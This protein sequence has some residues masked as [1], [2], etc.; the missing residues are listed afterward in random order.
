MHMVGTDAINDEANVRSFSFKGK[1]S[2]GLARADPDKLG[3]VA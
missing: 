1:I 2:S 3:N